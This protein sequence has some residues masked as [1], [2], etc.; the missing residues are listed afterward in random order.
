MLDKYILLNIQSSENKD[1]IITIIF[2][3]IGCRF[4]YVLCS[5]KLTAPAND[6]RKMSNL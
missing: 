2:M 6:T 1:I 3:D 4:H 5:T